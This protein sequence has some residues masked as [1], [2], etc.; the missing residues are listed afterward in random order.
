MLDSDPRSL[1]VVD[2]EYKTWGS[3]PSQSMLERCRPGKQTKHYDLVYSLGLFDASKRIPV[4]GSPVFYFI[5]APAA[6]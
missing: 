1:E 6:V 5:H 2:R 4:G 3:K